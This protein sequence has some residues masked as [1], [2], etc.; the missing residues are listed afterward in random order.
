MEPGSYGIPSLEHLHYSSIDLGQTINKGSEVLQ[1][2][3]GLGWTR[4]IRWLKETARLVSMYRTEPMELGIIYYTPL[5]RSA[6]LLPITCWPSEDCLE[7]QDTMLWIW[8]TVHNSQRMTPVTI[9]QRSTAQLTT[10]VDFGGGGGGPCGHAQI[11][12]SKSDY[13]FAVLASSGWMYLNAIEVA[14]LC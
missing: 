9:Q 14:V 2:C 10:A 3:I 4:C 6:M 8:T 7:I 12:V 11:T 5:S 1:H 13:N